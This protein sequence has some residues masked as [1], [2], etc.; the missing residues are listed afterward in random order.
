[1]RSV[2]ILVI[3]K[4]DSRSAVVRLDRIGLHSV[5]LLLLVLSS[6][7]CLKSTAKAH[8]MDLLRVEQPK[9]SQN[10]FV[11]LKGTASIHVLFIW[12]SCSP[13]PPPC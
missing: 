10:R 12:E 7:Q 11:T 3:N 2:I 5:L 9:R 13:L 6:A 8:V 1:M 4:S